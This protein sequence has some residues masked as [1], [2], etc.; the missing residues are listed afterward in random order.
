MRPR[1]LRVKSRSKPA[2][3]L[4]VHSK[5]FYCIEVMTRRRQWQYLIGLGVLLLVMA[6]GIIALDGA[7]FHRAAW[8]D[9]RTGCLAQVTTFEE[10]VEYWIVRDQLASIPA[11]ASL[12]LLGN[13]QYVDVV[14]P[15]GSQLSERDN[16]LDPHLVPADIDL[17]DPA[18]MTGSQRE[19]SGV[20]EFTVP[21]SL[22]GHAGSVL[23]VIRIGFSSQAVAVSIRHRLLL[24]V[25]VGVGS[26]FLLMAGLS[27]ALWLFQRKQCIEPDEESAI[28][29]GRLRIDLRTCDVVLGDARIDL[30]PKLFSLLV[31]FAQD[32]GAVLSET[33]I[34][35][36]LWPDSPYATASDV[37][38]CVY[39][40][41]Q[42]FADH[43]ADPKKLI[44]NV[45]GFGYRLDPD[46]LNTDLTQ[47]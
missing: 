40:L 5:A 21:I 16:E 22:S 28:Q 26:W 33:D 38:Q 17:A 36:E 44:A 35:P 20:L 29:C 6:G 37:K 43:H 18:L 39:M 2:Q 47:I 12:L 45:K 41:R 31:L 42:R 1:N 46:A 14:F 4:A 9:F 11:A 7:R 34:V 25:G 15:D 19:F 13:G 23:G 8:S 24:A 10:Y 3:T 27:A 30:P 32:P